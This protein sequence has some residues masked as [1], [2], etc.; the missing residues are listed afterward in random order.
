MGPEKLDNGVYYMRGLYDLADMARAE[1]DSA[2]ATWA[3]S[4]ANRLRRQ[5][6]QTWWDPS[7]SQYADSLDNPGNNQVYLKNW[8]DQVPMEATLTTGTQV[9]PGVADHDHG[10]AALPTRESSCFSGDRP[11]SRGLFHT[12]CGGGADG[13][14]D[15]EIFSLTTP[16]RPSARATTAAWARASSSATPTPTPRRCSPSPPPAAPRTRCRARCRRSS[17]RRR[18]AIPRRGSRPTSTGAGPA[19]RWSC[20]R[21]GT[22]ARS[23]R[24]SASSSACGRS[25]A[26]ARSQVVPQVPA[27]PAQRVRV[28]H[29]PRHGRRLDRRVRLASG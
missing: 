16:S 5:F 29:P 8:I 3:T 21:G 13:K 26:R 23:G 1:H 10:V 24:S 22:T 4:L 27:G 15:F 2:T 20:R 14:G 25:W 9:T 6:E 19:A 12:A 28:Q 7:V 17:R 18:R 11:G